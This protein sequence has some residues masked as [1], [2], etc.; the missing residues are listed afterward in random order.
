MNFEDITKYII[1]YIGDDPNRMDLKDTP[2]R[3]K[4][5]M[6]FVFSGYNMT[7][8]IEN[9]SLYRST[10]DQ[11]IC[12][13]KVSFISHCEHHVAPII[14]EISLGYIPDLLIAS[15][16]SLLR[17]VQ[18]FTRRLQIQ[19]RIVQQITDFIYEK[20]QSRGVISLIKAH[21]HCLICNASVLESDTEMCSLYYNGIFLED[22][23]KRNDFLSTVKN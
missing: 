20:T 23:N 13:K 16:G 17:T 15:L 2:E 1:E 8:P 10:S 21:H 14:G 6:D 11:M 9:S 7:N 19:E 22:E 4:Q 3:F 12:I 18:M 5:Y